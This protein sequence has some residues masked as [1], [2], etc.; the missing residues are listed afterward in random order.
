MLIGMFWY[1]GTVHGGSFWKMLLSKW[2]QIE[3]S[4]GTGPRRVHF[5]YDMKRE[6]REGMDACA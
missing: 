4:G 6:G 5:I 2:G 3:S 1:R